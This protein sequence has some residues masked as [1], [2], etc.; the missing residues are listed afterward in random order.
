MFTHQDILTYWHTDVQTLPQTWI[1]LHSVKIFST[2]M[3]VLSFTARRHILHS[4]FYAH[5]FGKS[6]FFSTD[7]IDNLASTLD[8]V[9]RN[10]AMERYRTYNKRH[11]YI[12]QTT[13]YIGLTKYGEQTEYYLVVTDR[14]CHIVTAYPISAG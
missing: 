3:Y 5:G 14:I 8:Y 4:H 7:T 2:N 13:K 6:L 9:R 10:H 12:I 1:F 11:K